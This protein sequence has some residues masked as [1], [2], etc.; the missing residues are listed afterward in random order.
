MKRARWSGHHPLLIGVAPRSAPWPT[1]AS[2]PIDP[3]AASDESCFMTLPGAEAWYFI[4]ER[5]GA[6]HGE[7]DFFPYSSSR[8][9]GG[10]AAYEDL[11]VHMTDSPLYWTPPVGKK[12]VREDEGDED[13]LEYEIRLDKVRAIFRLTVMSRE[14][15]SH[16][17]P[18]ITTRVWRQ[19]NMGPRFCAQHAQVERECG[20]SRAPPAQVRQ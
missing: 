19:H 12:R 13:V 3:P 4:C 17:S 20:F 2:F 15:N 16:T 14:F 11:D 8:P 5:L 1:S 7:L 10:G 9:A 18:E 6:G